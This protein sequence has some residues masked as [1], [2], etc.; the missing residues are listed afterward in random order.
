MSEQHTDRGALAARVAVEATCA[1]L[2]VGEAALVSRFWVQTGLAGVRASLVIFTRALGRMAVP[3]VLL[4]ALGGAA[5]GAWRCVFHSLAEGQRHAARLDVAALA[6]GVELYAHAHGGAAPP[7]L[8]ALVPLY[9]KGLHLDPW[10]GRYVLAR[11]PGAAVVLSLGPDGR[12][13]GGDDVLKRVELKD[14][15]A[16]AQGGWERVRPQ[17]SDDCPSTFRPDYDL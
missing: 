7:G 10:G 1:G 15:G 8:E 6:N 13:G 11:P 2:E 5:A 16:Q 17:V 14:D 3:A 4:A 12:L 9:L